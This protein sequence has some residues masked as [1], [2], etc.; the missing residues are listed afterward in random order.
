MPVRRLS[1]PSPVRTLELMRKELSTLALVFTSVS[2]VLD[3]ISKVQGG[4]LG[5][6]RILSMPKVSLRT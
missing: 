2:F 4:P 1:H 5:R 3:D 6:S